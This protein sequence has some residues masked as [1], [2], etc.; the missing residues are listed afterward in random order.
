MKK[1]KFLKKSLAMLLALMLVVAMIPLSAS[2][3]LPDDLEYLYINGAQV[4]VDDLEVN[5]TDLTAKV[6]IETNGDLSAQ[7]AELRVF[8]KGG[9]VN[10]DT[11]P[12]RTTSTQSKTFDPA[13]YADV[14]GNTATIKMELWNTNGTSSNY[15]DDKRL[16]SYTLTIN[17]VDAS[18]TTNLEVV[19]QTN[20]AA[21]DGAYDAYVEGDDIYVITARHT[22]TGTTTNTPITSWTANTQKSV[23]ATITVRPLDSA[24][25]TAWTDADNGTNK[26]GTVFGSQEISANDGDTVTVTSANG[27][28]STTYKI[29]AIYEE[30]LEGFTATVGETEYK[31][32]ITDGN[33]DDVEDTITLVLPKSVL[34]DSK[35]DDVPSPTLP[36]SFDAYGNVNPSVNVTIAGNT[37]AIADNTMVTFTNLASGDVNGTV[38]VSRLNGFTQEYKLVVKTEDSTNTAVEYVRVNATEATVSG[39]DISAVLPNTYNGQAVTQATLKDVVIYTEDTVESV[40]LNGTAM[41]KY[42]SSEATKANLEK[43]PDGQVSWILKDVDL[44]QP[45]TLTVT[46]EDNHFEEYTISTSM[47]TVANVAGLTAVWLRNGANTY[48]GIPDST[49]NTFKVEV[50]YMTTDI[51]SWDVLVTPASGSKIQYNGNYDLVNGVTKASDISLNKV[52]LTTGAKTTV[53]AVNGADAK[54]TKEYTIQITLKAAKSANTLTGLDFTSQISTNTDDKA[55]VRALS[56]ENQF[57]AYID[58]QSNNTYQV[59]TIN[60]SVPQSLRTHTEDNNVQYTYNNIVTGFEVPEGAV[61]YAITGNSGTNYVLEELASTTLPLAGTLT[62]TKI[63]NTTTSDVYSQILV[64]PEQIARQVKAGEAAGDVNHVPQVDANKYGTLYT[65][66]LVDVDYETGDDLL[67]IKIGDVKLQINTNDN[68]VTGT[69]PWSYTVASTDSAQKKLDSAKFFE[70][71]TSDYA[72]MRYLNTVGEYSAVNSNGDTDGDG[73]SNNPGSQNLKFFFVRGA[74]NNVELYWIYDVNS[75]ASDAIGTGSNSSQNCLLVRAEDRLNPTVGYKVSETKY[76][77]NLK[78]QDPS[79]EADIKSFSVAGQTGIVNNTNDDAR[80]ITVN[81]PYGTDMKG[82]VATFEA[83]LG[84]TV[85]VGDTLASAVDFVSGVTS[86]N[87]TNPVYVYVISEDGS[88]TNRYT[89]TLDEGLSFSDVKPGDWFYDNVMDAAENG[90][91]SGMGDGTFQPKKATTRAQFAS[92]IANALGYES[93]PDAASMFPDVAE[94]YWGKSAINFCVK[95]DILKGYDDGTFQ[96]EKPITRQEAASILRNA[97]KLTESSSETFPDDSA[98]SG[99]AKESVYIVKASGLMKG[100]AGTGN[101]RPTDTIIRA[102]AASIFMNAKYAGLIK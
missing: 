14:N 65:V 8:E 72:E 88:V 84:A 75:M 46:A 98:I 31:A 81:V 66:N 86:L 27:G 32:T 13:T 83:S 63:G 6:R 100:D 4:S 52:D 15:N 102:E 3:A 5:V 11:A 41:H 35:G 64:L 48:E 58:E 96:P 25:I 22:G 94:D 73:A 71:T 54:I 74:N 89:I 23:R 24:K 87:Y 34:K 50:P 62:G 30:A 92:M 7:Q 78:W 56:D 20:A 97:F 85:K 44:S 36:V 43:A 55:V 99:W 77:F 93:D 90:Y 42:G 79:K 9:S 70:F 49:T 95:N 29:H 18:T 17:K 45:R 28:N 91:V 53:T 12:A 76:T 60:L 21:G 80:T 82:L 57:H 26:T 68:I 33:N 61:A 39:S 16:A 37:V 2:A 51:S 69:L 67:T 10:Y 1:S 19:K 40:V 38:T 47:A 101:F 59:G